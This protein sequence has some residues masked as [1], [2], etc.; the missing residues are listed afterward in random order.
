L[1][2]TPP[3]PMP[4]DVVNPHECGVRPSIPKNLIGRQRQP[5]TQLRA[6][7]GPENLIA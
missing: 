6:M 4:S 3:L 7:C 2:C 5:G 1:Y